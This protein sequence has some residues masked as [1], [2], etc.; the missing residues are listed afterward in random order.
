[1]GLVLCS[2]K[3]AA[4]EGQTRAFGLLAGGVVVACIGLF[5]GLFL[6]ITNFQ[7]KTTDHTEQSQFFNFSRNYV[8]LSQLLQHGA[9]INDWAA[10][11]ESG[12]IQGLAQLQNDFRR[13][14]V[15]L[16]A[17]PYKADVGPALERL[18]SILSLYRAD[19]A[20]KFPLNFKLDQKAIADA[21]AELEA[22]RDS[23][24]VLYRDRISNAR[25]HA[26][27]FE[28]SFVLGLC[29]LLCACLYGLRVLAE[30][31]QR[32]IDLAFQRQ[33]AE[34][35]VEGLPGAVLVCKINGEIVGQSATVHRLLGY[36]P[37]DLVGQSID[38]LFPERFRA[39]FQVFIRNF[40]AGAGGDDNS[41]KGREMV[42]ASHSGRE[43]AMELQLGRFDDVEK[44]SMFLL[45]LRDVSDQK[46]LHEQYQYSEQR[47]SLAIRASGVGIW[48]WN[49]RTHMVYVSQSWLALVGEESRLPSKDLELFSRCIAADDQAELRKKMFDFLRSTEK[50]LSFEH[51]LKRANGR[52]VEVVCHIAA[53]R[54]ATGR[55]TRIVGVH[56]DITEYKEFTRQKDAA[57][58]QLQDKLRL[59]TMQITQAEQA[60]A[61]AASGRETF[62]NVVG[63]EIRTPMNAIVGMSDL[64]FKT[65]LDREQKSMLDTIR[66]SSSN[67]LA[68]LDGIVDF[69]ALESG[70][71]QLQPENVQLL[72]VVENLVE[73]FAGQAEKHKQ[74]LLLQVDPNLSSSFYTDP[75]RLRQVISA[76]LENAL[77]FSVY[78]V[79]RGIAQLRLRAAGE[80][81]VSRHS[82]A[83]LV[84]E[85]RDNGVGIPENVREQIFTAFVQV[86]GSRARRFGGLGLGLAVASGLVKLMG[87]VIEVDEVGGE[88]TCFR[89][90]LPSRDPIISQLSPV[91]RDEAMVLL[92]TEDARL[93]ENVAI[94]LQRYGW[95]ARQFGDRESLLNKMRSMNLGQDRQK[96]IL[97][98]DNASQVLSE[99]CEK[100]SIHRL[101]MTP[102]PRDAEA[103]SAAGVFLDPLLPSQLNR[104][105]SRL[106]PPSVS[107]VKAQRPAG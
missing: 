30:L 29:F 90:L 22:E 1:M 12:D 88:W 65:R 53:Q 102:R 26:L 79:P 80:T 62:F 95:W 57:L 96:L 64:L 101:L 37:A 83:S 40:L 71:L 39:Q 42:M 23:R 104:Q 4:S 97:L 82:W 16:R 66:R 49:L 28:I 45:Q 11:R 73:S 92:Y 68:T 91:S 69:S 94:A 13:S 35:L 105:L 86:E 33:R 36:R 44:G 51:Q 6:I 85:V 75:R 7:S 18:H 46:L 52:L 84:V 17:M 31:R 25:R 2:L 106:F 81:E 8:E 60:V 61:E 63:H 72:D 3:A 19:V 54:D 58:R 21:L 47:F 99:E 100:R 70:E 55:V 98:T 78:T 15:L 5:A 103:K 107:L 74:Q 24:F 14:E 34:S 9:I 32:S 43:M 93:R 38:M 48:D 10:R 89:V 20:G 56:R 87:G 67:L 76:L 77:K 50:T 27:T 59:A 41:G